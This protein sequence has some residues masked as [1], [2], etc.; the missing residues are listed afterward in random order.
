MKYQQEQLIM[1]IVLAF[2]IEKN[3]HKSIYVMWSKWILWGY[4]LIVK[5]IIFF[6]REVWQRL[7]ISFIDYRIKGLGTILR[8]MILSKQA[9]ILTIFLQYH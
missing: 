1:M 3:Q 7:L 8:I 6:R 9:I 5:R 2:S 4:I